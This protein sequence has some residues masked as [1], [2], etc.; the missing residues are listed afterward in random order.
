MDKKL[1]ITQ[2]RSVI[3]QRFDMKQT[4]VALGLHR[5]HHVVYHDD[6]ATIRG[7]IRKVRHLVKVEQD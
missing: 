7:M 4:I 6:T 3:G 2:T 1:K 5:I